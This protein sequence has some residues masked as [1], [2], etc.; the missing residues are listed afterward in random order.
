MKIE[1][2]DSEEEEQ[3]Q[4]DGDALID[5]QIAAVKTMKLADLKQMADAMEIEY[6]PTVTE[7]QLRSKITTKLREQKTE[8]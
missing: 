5:K 6:E 2:E 8:D 4:E 7:R 1:A 3:E